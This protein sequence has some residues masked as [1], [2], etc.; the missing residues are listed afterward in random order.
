MEELLITINTK[1]T[2]FTVADRSNITPVKQLH[3]NG[4][5]TTE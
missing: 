2:T 1:T 3:N 5:F 4:V